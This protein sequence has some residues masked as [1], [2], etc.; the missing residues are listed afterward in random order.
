MLPSRSNTAKPLT[1]FISSTVHDLKDVRGALSFF[2]RDHGFRVLRSEDSLF[3]VENGLHSYNVCTEIIPTADLVISIIDKRYGGICEN[4][5][6]NPISITRKE[7]RIAHDLGRPVWTFVRRINLDQRQFFKKA[8]N[9]D[10]ILGGDRV[11]RERLWKDLQN[12]GFTLHADSF[13]I[14]DLIDEITFATKDNWIWQFND[15]EEILEI[16]A[17]QVPILLQQQYA[18]AGIVVPRS[19]GLPDPNFNPEPFVT[20]SIM[21][22]IPNT[23]I[24]LAL[25]TL[26]TV[27]G[28][29]VGAMWHKSWLLGRIDAVNQYSM[30]MAEALITTGQEPDQ[31]SRIFV[32]DFSLSLLGP[33]IW[34]RDKFH[35]RVMSASR[36]AAH[37]LGLHG[38]R[39]TRVSILTNSPA[40]WLDSGWYAAIKSHVESH[41]Q[42]GIRLGFISYAAIQCDL[43][44]HLLNFYVISSKVCEIFDVLTG[45]AFRLD[46][47]NASGELSAF[48]DLVREI[49]VCCESTSGGFWVRDSM[50]IDEVVREISEL[51]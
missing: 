33:K 35:Q 32:S 16:L 47:V 42:F 27:H 39:Y 17:N 24:L 22:Q 11:G 43:T 28:G 7:L 18:A 5:G 6:V 23:Q 21:Y 20:R 36:R 1:V 12:S 29:N 34:S 13:D 2:L 25:N 19:I 4:D 26:K 15:T 37:E 38:I 30:N 8:C 50:S 45:L 31:S 44:E 46:H 14:Y 9:K 3:P 10:G 48:E 41:R 49:E 51:T 40:N